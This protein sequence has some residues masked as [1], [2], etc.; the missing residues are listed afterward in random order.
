MLVILVAWGGPDTTWGKALSWSGGGANSYWNNTTN[1]GGGGTPAN[2]DYLTFPAGATRLVNTNDLVGLKLINI[3]FTVGASNYN[4]YGNGISLTNG[5]TAVYTVGT[6]TVSVAAI[7][8]GAA[9]SFDCNASGAGLNISGSITNGTFTLTNNA[10]G[11]ISLGA[12][13]IGSTGGFVKNGAG[14]V[15]FAGPGDGTYTG[16]TRVN[17]GTLQLGVSGYNA[18]SGPLVIGDGT[19]TGS[20]TVRLLIRDEIPDGAAITINAGGVLDLNNLNETIGALTMQGGTASSG[21]GTLNLNGDLTVVA[22][23]TSATINGNLVFQGG[24]RTV[25]VADGGSLYDLNLLANVSDSGGGLL[26]TNTVVGGS[27]ARLTGSNYISGPVILNNLTLDAESSRSLGATNPVS[28]G[29]NG[30]LWLWSSGFTNK[31]LT[32]EAGATWVAQNT[33]A[34]AGPVTL[35]GDVT[36]QI[37]TAGSSLNVAGAISGIGG[38]TK[39]GAG[40]LI[41]N[42]GGNNLYGGTT[43]VN[44]G[45]LQLNVSG[46]VAFGGPLVIGD[47]TGTGSPVVQLLQSTEISDS[48]VITVNTGGLLDLNG[49]SDIIGTSLTLN[50]GNVQTGAGTLTLSANSTITV[51]AGS[52][53]VS[54]KLDVGTGTCTMQGSGSLTLS[55]NVSGSAAIVKNGAMYLYLYGANT[56]TNTFTANGSSGVYINNPLSLGVTNGGTTL[57]DQTWLAIGGNIIISN[58]PLILNSSY[59]GGGVLF[60]SD[61][62]T[63]VW[64]GTFSLNSDTPVNIL[65]NRALE[66][67]GPISGG[68]GISTVSG[69]GRLILSGSTA[70]SYTG[71]TTVNVGTLELNKSVGYAIYAGTLTV[72][73]GTGG[74][75]A[76]V[77]RYTGAGNSQLYVGVS[78]VVNSSGLLDLNGHTDDVG[79]V[80]LNGGDITTGA[81]KIEVAGNLRVMGSSQTAHITGNLQFWGV[82]RTITVENGSA[83]YALDISASVSDQ[84]NGFVVTNSTPNSHFLRL[85]SSNSFSGP[86]A[87]GNVFVSA[88][89]DWA[90]GQ[91]NGATSVSSNGVLWLNTADI[92]TNESLTLGGGS[93]LVAQNACSWAGPI[94]LNGDPTIRVFSGGSFEIMGRITGT[95]N[96]LMYADSVQPIRLSGSQANDYVGN[97]TMLYGTLELNK[98]A[99]DGAIPGNLQLGD[100]THSAT[101][102]YLQNNQIPNT[103]TVTLYDGS[104]LDLNNYVEGLGA[105][106]LYGADV[107]MGTGHLDLYSPG[108]ITSYLSTNAQ[109]RIFGKLGLMTPT[110]LNAAWL[111]AT[112]WFQQQLVINATIYGSYGFSKTG[113]MD[114]TLNASNSFTGPVSVNAGILT[115]GN[116]YAL[117]T[118]NA[119]TVVSNG[120]TLELWAGVHVGQEA[121]TL[122]GPG[123]GAYDGEGAL[124]G[125]SGTNSWAGS[126]TIATDSAIGVWS[127]NSQL[128]LLGALGGAG[129]FTKVGPGS[130]VLAGPDSSNTYAGNTTVN[131]GLLLLNSWNAIRYG[132]LTIGNGVGG[133]NTDVVRYLKNSCIYG[134]A[135]G[136]Q[137]FISNS[138]LLD[139]NG[140]TDDVGPITMDGGSITTG[141]GTLQLFSPLAT[142]S[143]GNSS[144]ISGQL[145]LKQDSTF[146]IT[147][148][149]TMNATVSSVGAYTLN[150]IGP[151]NLY[152]NSSNS[153][154]GLTVVQQGYLWAQN[155]GALGTA[156]SGTVVSNGASLV[157]KGSFGITNES[158]TLNGNGVNSNWGAL[159]VE[160]Q[161]GTNIWAGPITLNADSTISPW[162][163]TA[164]LRITGVIGGAGGLSQIGNGTLSLEGSAA[165]TYA[166]T[167]TV[168]AGATMLLAKTSGNAIPGPLDIFGTVSLVKALQTANSCN[169]TVESTGNFLMSTN[170]DYI[171]TLSGSGHVDVGTVWLAVGQNNGSSTF[172]GTISGSGS[173]YK[174]GSGT[175]ALTGPNTLAGSTH[176]SVGTL[177]VNG[178]QPQSPVIVDSGA[179]LGG[180]GIVGSINSQGIVAPGNS[181]G[182]LTS[183]NVTITASGVYAVQL[184]GPTPGVDYDQLNVR[185]TNILTSPT[186]SVS[187]AFTK[188]VGIGQQFVII[189]N[190]SADAVSGTFAGLAEGSTF[191]S[192]GFTFRI[193]YVGGTGND[194]V[195]TLMDVPT[196]QASYAVTTGNGNHFIDPNECNQINIVITN[197]TGSA[198]MDITGT[199]SSTNPNV[200]VTQPT[201]AYSNAVALGRSTNATAF[202]ISTLAGFTCGSDI[203]LNLAVTT[204]SH[205]TV[206][207]PVV[208]HTGEPAASSSRYDN[209]T[210]TNVPDYGTIESTNTVATWSGG[211]IAKVVVSLWL[212]APYSAEMTLTLISPDGTSVLLSSGNGTGANF[213][214]GTADANRTTFDDAAA[215]SIT[216]GNSPF[217][218]TFRPQGSLASLLRTAP[219]GNWRLRVTDG[220][221]S[222][223]PDTLRAWSLFL[224]GTTCTSGGGACTLC[225]GGTVLTNTLDAS[226]TLMTSRLPRDHV[227]STCGSPKLTC[228]GSV[229]GNFY[230]HAYPFYN[231][232]SNACITVT[233][234]SLGVDVMSGAYLGTVDPANACANYL[235]DYGD[236]TGVGGINT[237]SFAAPANSIFTVVVNTTNLTTGSYRLA[238]SGGDCTP[239]LS[240]APLGAAGVKVSWPD[241]SGA[242]RL[243]GTTNLAPTAWQTI[244]NEPV[245]ANSRCSV[246]NAAT[247]KKFFHL[248]KP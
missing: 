217:V 132:T 30:L 42:S 184:A 70:N 248:T 243:S 63:N 55:A 221:L 8:L 220:S 167:T 212:V 10:V 90:L 202:Q 216:A 32:L 36:V 3:Q 16:T 143:S 31:A 222:G 82:T 198:M 54:G 29:G 218:G 175:L 98:T 160:S 213:G 4:L 151:G 139:L 13:I 89:N 107:Q 186:L 67:S 155:S 173:L 146:A 239:V 145:Q 38:L 57:N 68:G 178:S 102:R 207:M 230:Y 205:G 152:L 33:C 28:I 78:T 141:A 84:G 235:A 144:S 24:L 240:I 125:T 96:L 172:D 164:T 120:A 154:T 49:Y 159:D 88:E 95:G 165:N 153:Y 209:N 22:S 210:I 64:Y 199:L 204:S 104:L 215:T 142:T 203:N 20:P 187:A 196:A 192:G 223:T 74:L 75:H 162:Y 26:F 208:L 76:D 190:D 181:P 106:V 148:D 241:V 242:Y 11:N 170:N 180:S 133:A 119:G 9:Q 17:A 122:N 66:L 177:L 25:S 236:S 35:N 114:V 247:G 97:T 245:V 105:L 12:N 126:V 219:V 15:T 19:G 7:T 158:L 225:A 188:P 44:A 189:N 87:I 131:E 83:G 163:G 46:S 214:S 112:S 41:Y 129:G 92:P 81:G 110:T 94:T 118:T 156:D 147:N 116:D 130:L 179:M 43:R 191:L 27:W 237:Y 61:N 197:K 176:V 69:T 140:F 48:A 134:G 85:L 59:S 124:F 201:S 21:S 23:A 117:G 157:L 229:P 79:P 115:L 109:S 224:Y 161:P 53:T 193:S 47:G 200:I 195:L 2:G 60:V 206:T 18:F 6:S 183:S 108:T 137:V 233:L 45:T 174:T 169:V 171:N 80:T 58:E 168:G 99:G 50:G 194:V 37:Y 39:T 62:S 123:S 127:T 166:G 73:D 14:T 1:W 65:A 246:T 150:K 71:D 182:T 185:G 34:W 103:R 52:S 121:L 228:P 51:N 138:G 86:L 72:G 135:G 231:G 100:A 91:T 211:P 128:A 113:P 244:T 101:N 93:Q 136:S 227:T 56:F 238:V 232:S 40:P 234:T 226:G 5:I 111:P 77:V 149:L